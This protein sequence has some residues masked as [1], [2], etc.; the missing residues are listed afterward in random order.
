MLRLVLA[1]AVCAGALLAAR[2][3]LTGCLDEEAGP[4]YVLRGDRELRPLALLEPG[5]G[6][7]TEGFA[8]YLGSKVTVRG[9][10]EEREGRKTMKVRSVRKV[11]GV[12]APA[13]GSASRGS[14]S[15][16]APEGKPATVTGCLDELP[17]PAY[18]LRGESDLALLM[19]LEPQGF[20]VT[21]FAKYLG[22]KVELRG[23]VYGQRDARTMKVTAIRPLAEVCGP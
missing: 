10:V 22:Q 5:Q 4:Q 3:S 12:C 6:F 17:G 8:K 13:A 7:T 15:R 21:G 9:E 18:A 23:R 14:A 1:A 20:P 19:K 16:E 11:A 2:S